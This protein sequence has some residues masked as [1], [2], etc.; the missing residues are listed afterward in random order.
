LDAECLDD[1]T[2]STADRAHIHACEY[3]LPTPVQRDNQCCEF[4]LGTNA[5]N[6]KKT[7]SFL[8]LDI[9]CE[10]PEKT[11]TNPSP[12]N[13]ITNHTSFTF[14]IKNTTTKQRL[15]LSRIRNSDRP[16]GLFTSPENTKATS[17]SINKIPSLFSERHPSKRITTA[18]SSRC[19]CHTRRLDGFID[20]DRSFELF[21]RFAV[22]QSTFRCNGLGGVLSNRHAAQLGTL[23]TLPPFS[24]AEVPLAVLTWCGTGSRLVV[25]AGVCET[26]E[27]AALFGWWRLLWRRFGVVVESYVFEPFFLAHGWGERYGRRALQVGALAWGWLEGGLEGAAVEGSARTL[28]H[29]RSAHGTYDGRTAGDVL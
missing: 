29:R 18:S 13:T 26:R 3:Y 12:E 20:F 15:S 14:H 27:E 7:K 8:Y 4:S 10:S 22:S 16:L 1:A 21:W 6:H 9:P 19:R 11:I 23:P 2:I 5:N 25:V 28:A 24:A 17:T